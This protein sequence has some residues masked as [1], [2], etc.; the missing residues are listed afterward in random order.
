MNTYPWHENVSP[1]FEWDP[2]KLSN[3]QRVFLWDWSIRPE[4]QFNFQQRILPYLPWE[5]L[6]LLTAPQ[7][8]HHKGWYTVIWAYTEYEVNPSGKPIPIGCP[9]NNNNAT[10]FREYDFNVWHDWSSCTESH[11]YIIRDQDWYDY[12]V[13]FDWYTRDLFGYEERSE[14]TIKDYYN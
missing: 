14:E 10:L 11:I 3:P 12:N 6:F 5:E 4:G 7:F 8:F 9:W 13:R 2:L 1:R